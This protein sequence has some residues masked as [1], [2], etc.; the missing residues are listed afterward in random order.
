M[1]KKQA[2][3]NLLVAIL[4]CLM[5]IIGVMTM[6]IVLKLDFQLWAIVLSCGGLHGGNPLDPL[7]SQPVGH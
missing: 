2:D 6:R 7:R 5:A 4:T 3:E 1:R